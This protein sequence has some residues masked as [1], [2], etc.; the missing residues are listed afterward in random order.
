MH[1]YSCPTGKQSSFSEICHLMRSKYENVKDVVYLNYKQMYLHLFFKLIY[2]LFLLLLLTFV[3]LL[4]VL[5][6][7][8]LDISV[9]R[10]LFL[11]TIGITAD[12]VME[13]CT[14]ELY[15]KDENIMLKCELLIFLHAFIFAFVLDT[16]LTLSS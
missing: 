1:R 4:L 12:K 10:I 5:V 16:Q 15:S 3:C 8:I 14:K 7:L 13:D 2:I 6:L 11:F 9:L